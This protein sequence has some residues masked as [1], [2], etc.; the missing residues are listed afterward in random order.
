MSD[1]DNEEKDLH[2]Y[3]GIYF[4]DENEKFICPWTGA[5]FKFEELTSKLQRVIWSTKEPNAF[6]W[7]PKKSAFEPI[8]E[9]RLDTEES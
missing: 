2:N 4:G 1:S 8:N 5:H 3:K 9:D 6:K 7:N